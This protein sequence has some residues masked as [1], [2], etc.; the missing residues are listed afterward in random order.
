[1]SK[2]YE[3]VK[4]GK[5]HAAAAP[6]GWALAHRA[7]ATTALGHALP[8]GAQIH[9]VDGNGHNNRP[10]NLVIC[11]SRAYHALLEQRQRA[12]AA[13]GHAEWRRCRFCGEY[14][15]PE[16]IYVR[17]RVAHH[18][19]CFNAY[20]RRRWH[21]PAKHGGLLVK[22]RAAARRR[23]ARNSSAPTEG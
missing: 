4:V 10:G 17:G 6:D 14:G 23:R 8:P 18:R 1:M 3:Y 12:R 19:E 9:H 20:L 13:C 5:G 16:S 7:I 22:E 21:D 15:D 11:E 2:T